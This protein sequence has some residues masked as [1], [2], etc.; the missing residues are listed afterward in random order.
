MTYFE[1]TTKAIEKYNEIANRVWHLPE[2]EIDQNDL[3]FMENLD[4]TI[5]KA[6]IVDWNDVAVRAAKMILAHRDINDVKIKIE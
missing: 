2:Y 1:N 3:E 5:A 4:F 6:L